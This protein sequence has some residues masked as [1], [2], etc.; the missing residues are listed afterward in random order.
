MECNN[1]NNDNDDTERDTHTERENRAQIH[2]FT[3]RQMEKDCRNKEGEVRRASL[4]FFWMVRTVVEAGCSDCAIIV[5]TTKTPTRRD[6][7]T[8]SRPAD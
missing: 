2:N 8:D 3:D 1:N 5:T 6:S 7:D 4:L